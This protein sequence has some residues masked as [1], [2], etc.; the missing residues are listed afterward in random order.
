[1]KAAQTIRQLG[2]RKWYER[3]LIHSHAHLVLLVLSAVG[4]LGSAEVYSGSAQLGDQLLI[5]LC[6]TASA[7]IGL[8]ALRRYVYLLMHAEHI[9]NQAVC[10]QCDAYA[11]WQP[12]DED[13]RYE[14]LSVRC[15]RCECRWDIDL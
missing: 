9:A 11:K 7:A 15:K 4:L 6:A 5:V 14:R 13:A 12:L 8:W 10:P 3:E 2:F 1:M